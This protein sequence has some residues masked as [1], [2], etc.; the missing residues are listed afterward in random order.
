[1]F[2]GGAKRAT[3]PERC[4]RSRS[5][6]AGRSFALSARVA[7]ALASAQTLSTGKTGFF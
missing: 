6:A 4:R 7:R 1:M 3:Q 2:D 5:P